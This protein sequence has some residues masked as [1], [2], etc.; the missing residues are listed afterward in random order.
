[1]STDCKIEK[2]LFGN[3]PNGENVH[4]YTL[5]RKKGLIAKVIDFGGILT[6]LHVPDANGNYTDVVL[7][8]DNVGSYLEENI[9]AGAIV[10]RTAGRITNGRFK[11]NNK[12]YLLPQNEGTT[13]LHGGKEGFDKKLW[14]AEIVKMEG[15]EALKLSYYSLD[16]EE[17]YPGNVHITVTYSLTSD[18]GIRIDFE[19]RTD[20]T[21]PLCPTSHAYFNLGGEGSGDILGH[22]LQINSDEIIEVNQKFLPT[23]RIKK[24]VVG[25]NDYRNPVPVSQ[26]VLRG[27]GH[28]HGGM[29]LLKGNKGILTKVASLSE[30]KSGRT[31]Y[32]YTTAPY[33]QLYTGSF[34]NTVS[35]GK[36]GETYGKFAGMCMECQGFSDALNHNGFESILVHPN[37]PFWQT[38]EYRFNNHD[39]NI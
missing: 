17:G 9:Y 25:Q 7:G 10:G 26:M 32:V 39:L 4:C 37:K 8:F 11:I 16:G 2:T 20:R 38:V 13:H 22:I 36:S 15:H 5:A 30:P 34:L 12:T 31:M 35:K 1:M 23:G 27:K 29:Y 6:E 3:G 19:A 28:V 18:N 14:D 21:T 33:L 24:T